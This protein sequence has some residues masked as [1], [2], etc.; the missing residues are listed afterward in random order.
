MKKFIIFI[1]IL[2][3]GI[4]SGIIIGKRFN[5][6]VEGVKK[7]TERKIAYWKAP[8]VKG[9]RSDKP[10]KS[11]MGMD[12]LP[13]YKDELGGKDD[14][15]SVYLSPL[16]I[17]NLGVRT[18]KVTSGNFRSR[19]ETV[20]YVDY[21][22]KKIVHIHLRA[23]GWV[24]KLY[25]NSIGERVK[26]GDLL[27]ELYSPALVNAQS[28]YLSALNTGRRDIIKA[29]E[30]RLVALD[31][32]QDL[33]KQVKK[34]RKTSQ[35]IKFYAPQDGIVSALNIVQGSYIT[36][37]TTIISLAD[38]SSIW[39][40]VDVF[41]NQVSQMKEGLPAIV[42]L[43][44][45]PGRIWKGKVSYIYPQIDPKTRTLKV[46]L[47]FDNP[48]EILKPDMYANVMILGTE[49][50]NTLS[51]PREALI[52][53]GNSERVILS[54]GNGMFQP[55]K[56]QSGIESGDRIEILSGLKE[57]E[58]IVTSSQ[59]L[60][61]SEASFKGSVIRMSGNVSKG[62]ERK[63]K[64]I[65]LK[66]IWGKGKINT[67]MKAHRMINISHDPIKELDWPQMDMD[68]I[69]SSDVDISVLKEGEEIH[70]RI[71]KTENGNYEVM[72]IMN[73]EDMQ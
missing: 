5:N 40:L 64:E 70:F 15:N 50:Q 9:F 60:I 36:P 58:N 61:D 16:V 39:I 54:K 18:G 72:Q 53:L 51:I 8:M 43:S 11:P 25:V 42:R 20:G 30:E 7:T 14:T 21:D 26:K 27:F 37:K 46:R 32:S 62:S 65:L 49:K 67:I 22:E 34:T 45:E 55:A 19:I 33:I 73:M 6:G 59:F 69:V 4:G 71:K 3:F 68:F 44:Y 1:I 66:D 38:L 63:N 13:V 24:N 52:R 57:G 35:Y 12:L 23:E 29:S 17:N 2:S 47:V 31:I 48:G 41:E 10:G 28:D 56:V